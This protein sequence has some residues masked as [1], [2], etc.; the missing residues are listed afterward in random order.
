ML[1]QIPVL[2][3]LIFLLFEFTF[4]ITDDLCQLSDLRLHNRSGRRNLIPLPCYCLDRLLQFDQFSLGGCQ[5]LIAL[6]GKLARLVGLFV[7]IR[8]VLA[9]NRLS[10]QGCDYFLCRQSPIEI[11]YSSVFVCQLRQQLNPFMSKSLTC[12]SRHVDSVAGAFAVRA[13]SV[14]RFTAVRYA[15]TASAKARSTTAASDSNCWQLRGESSS[16]RYG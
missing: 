13:L 8:V 2:C 7:L 16:F 4:A 10:F 12:P 9:C 3:D 1:K 6:N 5:F 14:S 15:E 11:G